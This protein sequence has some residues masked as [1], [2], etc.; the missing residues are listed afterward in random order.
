LS[1]IF[2][3]VFSSS[4][5][6]WQEKSVKVKSMLEQDFEPPLAEIASEIQRLRAEIDF[7]D[8]AT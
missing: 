3:F 8:P 1:F 4:L 2:R 5:V 6:L 7:E